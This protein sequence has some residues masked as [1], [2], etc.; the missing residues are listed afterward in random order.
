MLHVVYRSSGGGN[1]KNRPDFFDK[2]LCLASFRRALTLAGPSVKAVFLND[3]PLPEERVEQ[4][5]AAGLVVPGEGMGN[6][7]SYRR[8]L[9]LALER[10]GAG[11]LVYLAEDD[12]LLLPDAFT[13]LLAATDAIPEADYFTLYDHPDRYRRTDDK[14]GGRSRVFLGGVRHW[15]SVESTCLSFAARVSA[16]GEDRL[17]HLRVAEEEI[18][19]DRALWRNLQG[20]SFRGMLPGGRPRRLLVSPIPALATHVE[21]EHLSPLVDWDQVARDT[22][23]WMDG[24]G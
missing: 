2:D 1:R 10:S 16:L 24:N 5:A 13:V 17:L 6:G 4:M 11:D 22:R 19:D 23:A 12:Y 20:L 21:T 7:G 3:G 8:A 9:D 18:P 15:R 14:D